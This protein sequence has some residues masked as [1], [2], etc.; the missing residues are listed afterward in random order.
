MEKTEEGSSGRHEDEDDGV[1]SHPVTSE[2]DAAS[3]RWVH[4]RMWR[5]KLE[6]GRKIAPLAPSRSIWDR[7]LPHGVKLTPWNLLCTYYLIS[8]P[9]II[10][11]DRF[12]KLSHYS[13]RRIT[14]NR[15][16]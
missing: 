10:Q 3:S 16:Y 7:F 8:G 12:E 4:C 9:I 2:E 6:I 1:H 14:V 15:I 13:V 11:F 5:W